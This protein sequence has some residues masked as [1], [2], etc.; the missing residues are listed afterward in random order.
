MRT[1][2][3]LRYFSHFQFSPLLHPLT[4]PQTRLLRLRSSWCKSLC[5]CP[6]TAS[7]LPSPFPNVLVPCLFQ[8]HHFLLRE[9]CSNLQTSITQSNIWKR[10][11]LE[12]QC[13]AVYEAQALE[14][15]ELI[16]FSCSRLSL[17][18]YEMPACHLASLILVSVSSCDNWRYSTS[19]FTHQVVG[20]IQFFQ[21][22]CTVG[23]SSLHMELSIGELASS[24]V[25]SEKSQR[26]RLRKIESF[27]N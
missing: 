18:R 4:T 19:K 23:L 2:D 25:A 7:P 15:K 13:N 10:A 12:K 22:C 20:R 5:E 26:E 8:S 21:G 11:H 1:L 3:S 9:M 6:T 14:Q 27:I 16:S 17:A 24:D